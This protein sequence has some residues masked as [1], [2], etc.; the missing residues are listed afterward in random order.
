MT[1]KTF[2]IDKTFQ[3]KR[4]QRVSKL[5]KPFFAGKGVEKKRPKKILNYILP[6]LK[7]V[8]ELAKNYKNAEEF[9]KDI[10]NLIKQN[11]M[12]VADVKLIGQ[13]YGKVKR[14]KTTNEFGNLY[15]I[16]SLNHGGCDDFYKLA[17]KKDKKNN[18]PTWLKIGTAILLA[19]VAFVTILAPTA[20]ALRG[21]SAMS[22]IEAILKR[23]EEEN[24]KD[25]G[26][27]NQRLHFKD[28]GFESEMDAKVHLNTTIENMTLKRTDLGNN[29]SYGDK[30][31][32]ANF[33]KLAHEDISHT[34]WGAKAG[35]G[36][37][38]YDP[39]DQQYKKVTETASGAEANPI[40]RPFVDKPDLFRILGFGVDFYLA[41]RWSKMESSPQKSTEIILANLIETKMLH[42]SH[43]WQFQ[44][45]IDFDA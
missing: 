1:L 33:I 7:H 37:T 8:S 36:G 11:K 40:V 14:V 22:E 31:M 9:R 41:D 42:G 20:Q 5:G 28:L 10:R 3:Q 6:E 32:F 34:T 26:L 45:G 12:T 30:V 29:W 43:S 19:I 18:L 25:L 4:H 13:V 38:Y 17:T 35:Y 23:G 16:H 15:T 21:E 39:I 44:Y 24:E 2:I 27:A